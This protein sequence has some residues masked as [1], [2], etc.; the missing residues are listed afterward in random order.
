MTNRGSPLIRSREP[1]QTN[2]ATSESIAFL[3]GDGVNKPAGFLTFAT[4]AANQASH[5]GGAL[6]V[7]TAAIK[8]DTLSDF[9]FSLDA[10]Y[11]QNATWLMSSLTAAFIAKLK[12]ADGRPIWQESILVG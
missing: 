6:Q 9:L 3:S 7:A 11:R 1:V 5:P 4:G 10:P 12:D 2:R 8:V